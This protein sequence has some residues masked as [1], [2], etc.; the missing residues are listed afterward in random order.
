MA[1]IALLGLRTGCAQRVFGV[2]VTQD[3]ARHLEAVLVF[4]VALRG[5]HHQNATAHCANDT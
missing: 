2:Q 3:Q 5:L 4:K 1:F